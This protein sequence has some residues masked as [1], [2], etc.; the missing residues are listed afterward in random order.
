VRYFTALSQGLPGET[1]ENDGKPQIIST[2]FRIKTQTLAPSNMSV[3]H[4]TAMFIYYLRLLSRHL[5]EVTEENYRQCE[6]LDAAPFGIQTGYHP[7]M[8]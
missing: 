6:T 7:S 5:A 1:E 4:W 3:I 8:S 2:G